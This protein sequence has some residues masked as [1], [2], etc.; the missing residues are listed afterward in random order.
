MSEMQKMSPVIKAFISAN[1]AI[2]DLS[3]EERRRVIKAT[4]IIDGDLEN[5]KSV[6]KFTIDDVVD[7]IVSNLFTQG[8]L[9]DRHSDE[10]RD[11]IMGVFDQLPNKLL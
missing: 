8:I 11:V 9:A 4:S 7:S 6:S 5:V 3:P 2:A 10:A 1:E